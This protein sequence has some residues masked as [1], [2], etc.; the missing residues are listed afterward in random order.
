LLI[1]GLF[2]VAQHGMHAIRSLCQQEVLHRKRNFSD[3]KAMV[4]GRYPAV[5]PT[6]ANSPGEVTWQSCAASASEL[7]ADLRAQIHF[8]Q[9]HIERVSYN[10]VTGQ[11]NVSFREQ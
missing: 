3:L 9:Q 4:C 6:P 7:P 10:G 5:S 1:A 11:V 2:T 8:A